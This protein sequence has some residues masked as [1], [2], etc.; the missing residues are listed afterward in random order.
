MKKQI[1]STALALMVL[2]A[3]AQPFGQSDKKA[4][5]ADTTMR[6]ITTMELVRDMGIG[7]NLG[8]TMEACGDWIKEVDDQWGDGVLTVEEYE[9]A[10]GSPVITQKMIQ[11][12]ADEGFGVVRVPVA[13]SNLMG[14]NYQISP[15]LDARVHEIVDWVIEAD[16]YCIINIHWD[17][18]WVN[19]FPDN[20]DECMKRYQTMWE[21]IS[22]SFKDYG[23]HLMFE[24]QN[25]ELGW[26]SVW[27]PWGS[28]DGK[29]ESYALVNE[30]NQ[31]FV[32]VV[33]KSGG[34]NPKR[35]LL[36]SGYNTGFDRTCDPLFKMP[37]DPANR[38]AVS[39]HYYTPAGFAIL[40]DKDESW[41]KAR[42]T[43]GTDEDYKEL[44]ANMDMMKKGFID[45]GIP[46]IVG[47]YGCPTKGKDADSVRL[48]LSSVCKAAYERQL[49][50]VLWATPDSKQDDG[51]IIKGHYDR[52]T[53]KMVDQELKKLFN[54]ISGFKP[55][56]PAETTTTTSTT[57]ST[58][59]TTVTT[60]ETTTT[61]AA[62]APTTT[63]TNVSETTTSVTS[64]EPVTST[65]TTAPS[66][67]KKGD[68]NGDGT[69]DMSDVVLIMQSLANP[70]KFGEN[71]TDEHHITHEGVINGDVAGGNDGLTSGDALEIQLFLL[72]I[73]TS[74]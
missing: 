16:M 63:A 50:P 29:A 60:T 68:A 17:N 48:F 30:I 14:D 53:C 66:A 13:W 25:E 32:D 4:Y 41:A 43:W 26:E 40:E 64:T 56:T 52:S 31:K 33:R 35:H 67:G 6:D 18:G 72:G 65:T 28:T 59:T 73:R 22:D 36:I 62:P 24:S 37:N 3:T 20:K 2:T 27:N 58:A 8:N 69:V 15:D 42:S 39:V 47:E 9:T 11:G 12:M 55:K 21:Q 1:I 71:G 44:N 70:N 45:K 5:A 19:T 61:T 38:M 49:C 74:L 23:D 10:W 34:N 57:T 7:I 46:V 51:T 54:E